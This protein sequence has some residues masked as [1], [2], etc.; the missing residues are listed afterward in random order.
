MILYVAAVIAV[1]ALVIIGVYD[2]IVG[3]RRAM[4]RRAVRRQE[5]ASDRAAWKAKQRERTK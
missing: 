1:S 5:E 2:L 3:F 4:D